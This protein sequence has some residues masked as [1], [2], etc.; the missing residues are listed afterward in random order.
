MTEHPPHLE[1]PEAD[2]T[3]QA[4]DVGPGLRDPRTALPAEADEADVAEQD[5]VV[6]TDDEEYR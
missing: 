5:A 2:A 1:A 3:E 6:E 4:D